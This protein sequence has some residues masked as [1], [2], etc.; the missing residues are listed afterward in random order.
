MTTEFADLLYLFSCAALGKAPEED[1]EYNLKKIYL[2]AE[3]QQIDTII[4]PVINKLKERGRN[5]DST[6]FDAWARKFYGAVSFSAKRGYYISGLLKRLEGENIK[7]CILKGE[8]LSDLYAEP[9]SRISGD[10][11]LW[12]CSSGDMPRVI[13]LLEQD[14]FYTE[15]NTLESHQIECRHKIY[16]LIELHSDICDSVAKQ[17]WF[18][19]KV[20]FSEDFIRKSDSYGGSFYAL[21]ATD[22]A[23]FVTFHFIKHFLSHGCGCR[24]L[25]DMLLY[26]KHYE[27][28]INWEIF[29]G[30]YAEL[31]YLKFIDKCKQIG[32]LYFGIDFKDVKAADKSLLDKI[33]TDMEGSG[34]FGESEEFRKEFA[35]YYTKKRKKNSVGTSKTQFKYLL[36]RISEFMRNR[37]Y[38]PFAIIRDLIKRNRTID[39]NTEKVNERLGLFENLGFFEDIEETEER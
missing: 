28:E 10:I 3:K 2:L 4:F 22:G 11:D 23:I 27:N 31:K 20:S 13:E 29:N 18:S 25:M 7:Y 16:G 30:L 9:D 36:E 1:R 8:S 33:L 6:V 37:N 17:I 19:D 5:V 15:R 14:G 12:I 38:N 39:K 21:S 32:K 24:Q 26:L 35:A 34:V